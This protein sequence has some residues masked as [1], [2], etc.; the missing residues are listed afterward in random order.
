MLMNGQQIGSPLKRRLPTSCT[1]GQD[2][3]EGGYVERSII[4]TP[5][6][7]RSALGLVIALACSL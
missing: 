6:C 1:E 2:E 3:N 5:R 7:V 4:G